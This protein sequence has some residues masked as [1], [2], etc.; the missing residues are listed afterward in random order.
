MFSGLFVYFLL[1]FVKPRNLGYV[2]TEAGG[3]MIAGE[4][5]SPDVAYIS[6]AKQPE[7]AREGYNPVPPDLVVEVDYPSTYASQQLL[8]IKVV[9]YLAAGVVVW[10][11]RPESKTVA[12]YVPGEPVQIIGIDGTLDGGEV[13]PGFTLPLKDVFGE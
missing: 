11:V 8:L 4:R 9:N 7:Q 12:V 5:Y 6:K 1:A 10:L 2:T 3:Y 13:L